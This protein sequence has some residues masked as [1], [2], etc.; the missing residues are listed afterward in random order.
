MSY[1]WVFTKALSSRGGNPSR[2]LARAYFTAH[3]AAFWRAPSEAC[4]LEDSQWSESEG[5][6]CICK[7]SWTCFVLFFFFVTKRITDSW[8]LT[9]F[10]RE[11]WQL[12]EASYQPEG[13]R[14]LDWMDHWDIETRTASSAV[15]IFAAKCISVTVTC[16]CQPEPFSA[17]RSATN[18]HC[19]NRWFTS[20]CSRCRRWC[21]MCRHAREWHWSGARLAVSCWKQSVKLQ[22]HFLGA[23]SWK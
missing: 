17:D 9:D 11:N 1:V 4:S 3:M 18:P 10:F 23:P 15:F 12:T 22:Q 7:A 19:S 5:R 21:R 2:V 16:P 14:L 13:P 6:C 20:W 8:Q